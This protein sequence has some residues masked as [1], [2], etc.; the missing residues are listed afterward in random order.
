MATPTSGELSAFVQT[1]Q[2][3]PSLLLN[4][5]QNRPM[6]N[7]P[8]I[9]PLIATTTTAADTGSTR[10]LPALTLWQLAPARQFCESPTP[11]LSLQPLLRDLFSQPADSDC[12]SDAVSATGPG[13]GN[14][15]VRLRFF[16]KQ[17]RSFSLINLCHYVSHILFTQ[18]G[19]PR[20]RQNRPLQV[21]E[22]QQTRSGR[23][24]Q[25]KQHHDTFM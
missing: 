20:G 17:Q 6:S 7:L 25:P 18:V 9:T 10:G 15:Q 14:G 22:T 12:D 1:P 13:S 24:S 16:S 11:Q 2:T 5:M 4:I 8:A 19:R 3:R 23:V 21:K